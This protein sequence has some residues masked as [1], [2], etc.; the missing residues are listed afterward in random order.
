MAEAAAFECVLIDCT[1]TAKNFDVNP[2]ARKLMDRYKVNSWPTVLFLDPQGRKIEKMGGCKKPRTMIP[3]LH[4][5]ALRYSYAAPL[6]AAVGSGPEW[7]WV[8]E[9]VKALQ[10]ADA[11]ARAR[12]RD[13]LL[14]VHGA[15]NK[16]LR[17]GPEHA[18]DGAQGTGPVWAWVRR[19]IGRL[20][21]AHRDVRVRSRA[22][23]KD[24][25]TSLR[26][27]VL[28]QPAPG[29]PQVKK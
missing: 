9:R 24:L 4:R 15:L 3:Q 17:R 12:A 29:E 10:G 18:L 7:D 22:R 8:T 25:N 19:H 1:V 23:L 11:G 13:E 27:A 2:A 6:R 5:I 14:D 21:S 20:G 16:A 28:V 26:R